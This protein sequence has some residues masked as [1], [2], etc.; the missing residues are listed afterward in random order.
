[1]QSQETNGMNYGYFL[2]DKCN[3]APLSN[4][5]GEEIIVIGVYDKPGSSVIRII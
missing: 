5:V 2:S 4:C 3:K 1:M